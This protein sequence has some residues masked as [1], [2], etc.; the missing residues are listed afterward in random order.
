[1][2]SNTIALK[3]TNVLSE[4]M[5]EVGMVQ[6]DTRCEDGKDAIGPCV[7]NQLVKCLRLLVSHLQQKDATKSTCSAESNS[8]RMIET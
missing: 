6:R 4:R 5:C 8:L 3:C 7:R 2:Y 1:M